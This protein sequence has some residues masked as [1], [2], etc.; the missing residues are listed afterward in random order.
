MTNLELYHFPD[1]LCS[2]KV[3]LALAEKGLEWKSHVVNLLTF[4]NL[5]PDYVRLNPKAVVPTLIHN[6]KVI[7]NSAIIVRYLD[8]NF[9]ENRLTLTEQALVEKMTKWL[10]LQDSFPMRELIYGN[11]KGIDGI[12]ARRSVRMKKDIIAKLMRENPDLHAQ[13]V[14]KLEDVKNWNATVE[15]LAQVAGINERMNKILDQLENEVSKSDWLCGSNYSLADLVWTAV[16]HYL[17]QVKLDTLWSNGRRSAI[18]SY[19]EHLKARPSYKMAIKD[20]L[21]PKVMQP[22]VIAGLRRIFLGF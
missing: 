7:C 15:N 18:A 10:D 13:Y 21:T 14:A 5:K 9:P 12:V 19:F 8:E 17:E 2:Q 22:V 4:E 6:G 11:M 16:L 20:F 1:S 3:R